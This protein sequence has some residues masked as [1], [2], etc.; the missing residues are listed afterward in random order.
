MALIAFGQTFFGALFL[1]FSDTIFTNSLIALLPEYAPLADPKAVVAAGATGLRNVVSPRLLPGVLIA[2]AKSVDRV[3]Y[4]TTGAA[5]AGFI[6]S[7]GMGWKDIRPK[8]QV[9]KA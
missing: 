4:L 7:W 8:K 6:V 3:F 1:C 9:G 5:V 2:Y